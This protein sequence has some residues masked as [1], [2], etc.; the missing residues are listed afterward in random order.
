MILPI[1]IWKEIFDYCDTNTQFTLHKVCKVLN[2]CTIKNIP[3]KKHKYIKN[4][5]LKCLTNLQELY[6]TGSWLS[7]VPSKYI[8]KIKNLKVLSLESIM[9]RNDINFNRFPNLEKL[10]I[11]DDI[12][13]NDKILETATS[14]K[15]LHLIDTDIKGICLRKLVNLEKLVITTNEKFKLDFLDNSSEYLQKLKYL[16]IDNDHIKLENLIQLQSLVYL[17]IRRVVRT[18]IDIARIILS[19]PNLKNLYNSGVLYILENGSI[20]D[21]IYV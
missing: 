7:R 10:I 16:E 11:K 8:M 1:D 15:E 13:I 5:N 9:L 14:V 21:K 12:S 3:I 17:K 19:M 20:K 18:K 6:L 4:N 2:K